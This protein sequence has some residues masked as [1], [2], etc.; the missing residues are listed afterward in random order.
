[1]PTFL[2]NQTFDKGMLDE[3][4]FFI[5]L[6]AEDSNNRPN[7]LFWAKNIEVTQTG[8]IISEQKQKFN[9]K[10]HKIRVS[11]EWVFS[12]IVRYFSFVEFKKSLKVSSSPLRHPATHAVMAI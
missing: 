5:L 7:I 11:V 1:M 12:D 8:N 9:Q 10:M 4:K 6:H 2:L 3:K